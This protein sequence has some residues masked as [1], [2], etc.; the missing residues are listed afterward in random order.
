MSLLNDIF[1][2]DFTKTASSF[3][4]DLLQLEIFKKQLDIK[5]GLAEDSGE[6]AIHDFLEN[7]EDIQNQAAVSNAMI[8]KNTLVYVGI[9]LAAILSIAV[10]MKMVK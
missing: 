8:S 5:A 2:E 7:Q 4:S 1:G 9:G 3:G 6:Q 10:V